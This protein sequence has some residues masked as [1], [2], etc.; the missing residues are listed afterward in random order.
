MAIGI[1]TGSGTYSLPGFEG[2]EPGAG[3]HRLG[4]R[5]RLARHVRGHRGA[6]RL[7]PREGHRRLSNLVTHRANIAA[8]AQLGATG[9]IAVTV[10]GAVDPA[11][12]ARLARVLRRPALPRQPARRRRAVHV[13]PRARRSP[14]RALD[15]RGPVLRAAARRRCS[16]GGARGR[17]ADPRR[18]RATATSTGRA[19]T[20]R[21]E[22]RGLA[23]VRRHARLADRRP[24]GGAVRR[25]R[26][27]VRAARLRDR[28]RQ[29]RAGR[30][31]RPCR[32]C[33]T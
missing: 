28:L 12:R 10:C 3:R 13:L 19:S 15:L 30:G 18:R 17:R 2:S 7:A 27:A 20:P 5:A 1:I 25:G 16:T 22:I 29:R 21:A 11:R 31:R 9:V 4:R 26:A 8:L 33:S 24:R 14:P 23:A 32:R 6:A